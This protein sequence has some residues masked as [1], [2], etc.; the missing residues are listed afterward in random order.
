MQPPPGNTSA[1]NLL[2][3]RRRYSLWSPLNSQARR[4]W[5]W[6]RHWLFF[7]GGKAHSP[8]DLSWS[9][10]GFSRSLMVGPPILCG[11]GLG[12]LCQSDHFSASIV[13]LPFL[14]ISLISDS[15][16]FRVILIFFRVF[17]FPLLVSRAYLLCVTLL[18]LIL[19]P[20][21]P[22]SS[23]PLYLVLPLA[24]SHLLF[25]LSFSVSYWLSPFVSP[26]ISV[27]L[28]VSMSLS[29]IGTFFSM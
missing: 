21:F 13:P 29:S 26:S 18:I 7:W 19:C 9:R 8:E 14:L 25:F 2:H 17:F 24:L 5:P 12:A 27:C 6:G 23:F 16:S 28:S 20:M 22:L 3:R 4:I 10:L 11:A 1:A 15:F